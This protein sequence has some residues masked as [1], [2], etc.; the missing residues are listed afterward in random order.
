M[1]V[2]IFLVVLVAAIVVGLVIV[3][4]VLVLPVAGGFGGGNAEQ[5]I[6]KS[7]TTTLSYLPPEPRDGDKYA[8]LA[9]FTA[10]YLNKNSPPRFK[11]IKFVPPD[12]P[13]TGPAV[14]S[15]NPIDDHTWGAVALSLRTGVCYLT[16]SAID[17]SDTRLG[18]SKRGWL[19]RGSRCVGEAATKESV[20]D[21]N[22]PSAKELTHTP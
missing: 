16:L 3:G 13:S 21:E 22:W 10:D 6:G 20:R 4:A 5:S 1:S 18:G 2:K 17:P 9:R 11:D 14:V 19:P 7:A 12:E 8:G 15:V